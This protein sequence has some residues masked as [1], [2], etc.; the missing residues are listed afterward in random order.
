MKVIEIEVKYSKTVQEKQYE[1]VSFEAKMKI[2]VSEVDDREDQW[3]EAF[4]EVVGEVKEA[5][6]EHLQK[7][8]KHKRGRG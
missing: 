8:E 3:M 6:K 2:K 5:I 4:S 7:P 1:P